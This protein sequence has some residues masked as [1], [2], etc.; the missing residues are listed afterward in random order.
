MHKMY[1]IYKIHKMKYYQKNLSRVLK[2]LIDS[3]GACAPH[4]KKRKYRDRQE[5][6]L[7]GFKQ[8]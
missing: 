4:A 3:G 8:T 7:D 6:I 2:Q 1:K 5:L